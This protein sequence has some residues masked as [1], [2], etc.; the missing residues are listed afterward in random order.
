MGKVGNSCSFETEDGNKKM[1]AIVHNLKNV[2]G[3]LSQQ[4]TLRLFCDDVKKY[5]GV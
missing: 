5:N 1:G 3:Y 4:H 2:F